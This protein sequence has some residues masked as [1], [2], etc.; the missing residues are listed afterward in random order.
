MALPFLPGNSFN[1]NLGKVKYHKSHHFDY[2]N[3]ISLLVGA[4]KPGIGGDRLPF[5]KDR[6]NH[7]VI[8]R[9]NGA[10][11]PTWVAFDKQVLCY[12]AYF[13]ESVHEKREEQFRV[14]RCK[15]YFY[16][17]DDSIQVVEPRMKNAGLP[18][19]TIIR[20]HRIN[21]PPPYD[22]KFYTL[23][24]FDI[25][26][27]ITIYAR[28]YKIVNCDE[29][30][31]NF[32]KKMGVRLRPPIEI[33]D[34]P[35][36]EHRKANDDTMQPLRPYERRDTLKQ[37]L[38]HDRHVLRFYCFW[39]DRENAFGD[40]R[41]MVLHYYLADDTIE[42]REM[43]PANAGR[44][45]VPMFLHRGK[46]PK[47]VEPLRKPGEVADRTVLNVFGPMG[48]GGRYILDNLKTGNINQDFYREND[49]TIGAY[50][51]VWGRKF[52]ICDCDEFTKEYYRTK[53][54]IDDFTPLRVRKADS[55]NNESQQ[56]A[57]ETTRQIPPYN[58][59]GSE[60]DSLNSALSLLPRPPKRDFA[61]FMAK[62]RKGLDSNS[63]RF[64]AKLET[65]KP[66][67]VDRR[68][69]VSYFL[70]DDTVSVFE[71]VVKNSG[72]VG[73]R[74][75]ERGRV[76]KPNQEEFGAQPSKY[77]SENDFYVGASVEF[78]KHKFFLVDADEY[79]YNYME[80]YCDKFP[81]SNI[82]MIMPKLGEMMREA[83][84]DGAGGVMSIDEFQ[85]MLRS[86]AQGRLSDQEV[87]TISRYYQD[88]GVDQAGLDPLIGQVQEQLKRG[89]FEDFASITDQ[90]YHFDRDRT[91]R[92]HPE[93]LRTI[94]KSMRVPVQ[95]ELLRT[96]MS[97]LMTGNQTEVDYGMV[98]NVINWRTYRV[99]PAKQVTSVN[100][101]NWQGNQPSSQI[102]NVNL[103]ALLQ[104]LT[105]GARR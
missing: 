48:Q 88:G 42:V 96:L 79:A 102:Q 84:M 75:F 77:Y 14:H 52:L 30:T 7:S 66:T 5:Q 49:L 28:K 54:G 17:E 97:A 73:G 1:R 11:L 55:A 61:K 18:Q 65:S 41:E 58:G 81:R 2:N 104:D 80:K 92:L 6:P 3:D 4:E 13:Q 85:S 68:F 20:R 91:G 98:V 82:Q 67:E 44:D 32:M 36:S 24:D 62:D 23:E 60:E 9:G 59:F 8:P 47:V 63:L 105:G 71:P 101:E 64:F 37:F 15:I 78:N 22:D 89:G 16:L 87:I 56:T 38:D 19:G 90:C 86:I 53:Y 45:T 33:P 40:P 103:D 34:D 50:V 43:I 69:V 10:P 95:D 29:F 70:A 72:I 94:F 21:R 35:F 39:D 12:D 93:R 51:N 31:T 27:E 83:R 26:N 99:E 100:D 46:V 25:G 76:K 74:F 57:T